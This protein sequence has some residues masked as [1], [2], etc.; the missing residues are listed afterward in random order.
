[1]RYVSSLRTSVLC[2]AL[3]ASP[4]AAQQPNRVADVQNA[5]A[6]FDFREAVSLLMPI[7]DPAA[8]GQDEVWAAAV[9]TLA[10]VLL[11]A[12]LEN[13]EPNPGLAS[14]WLRWGVRTRG[15]LPLD[16]V[17][18]L[19]AVR[20]TY[21]DVARGVRDD[22]DSIVA[23]GTQW[24]WT[25]DFD[26]SAVGRLAV[27]LD[28]DGSPSA[29][30]TADGRPVN[31]APTPF[32][33]GTYEIE[34][35]VDGYEPVTLEREVLP[36]VTTRV[37]VAPAPLLSES[38]RDQAGARVLQLAHDATNTRVCVN[39]L[40]AGPRSIVV[41]PDVANMPRLERVGTP[42]DQGAMGVTRESAED[43]IAVVH[44]IMA[45][46]GAPE[47]LYAAAN[48]GT[49][50][51]AL[52]RGACAGPLLDERVQ[53]SEVGPRS[54]TFDRSLDPSAVGGALIDRSGA[55][56]GIVAAPDRATLLTLRAQ[57][58]LDRAVVALNAEAEE[59]A[60]AASVGGGLPWAWIGGVGG[61]GALAA[62]LLGGNPPPPPPPP[63]TTGGITV[64]LPGG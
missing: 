3:A 9:K 34:V 53:L 55:V 12:G 35:A 17:Y 22:P 26:A 13:A 47:A 37:R 38:V 42:I 45:V 31:S 2:I 58:F 10:T 8:A 24:D 40:V 18:D 41:A 6:A 4:A 56:L 23:I 11:D 62:L 36:G 44:P 7:L 33:A 15:A 27:S 64:T 57:A 25:T 60:A 14:V 43:A 50:A 5:A 29:R 59:A 49:F 48:A 61:A 21:D 39:G 19:E 54:A 32:P 51:W 28:I 16:P 30:V 46:G 52:Y 20:A 1:M 63:P